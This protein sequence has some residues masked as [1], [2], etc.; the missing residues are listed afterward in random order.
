MSA[1]LAPSKRRVE[2][3]ASSLATRRGRSAL[4]VALLAGGGG[5]LYIRHVEQQAAVRR[6]KR[7]A[8]FGYTLCIT[9]I[10]HHDQLAKSRS[11]G[12]RLEVILKHACELTNVAVPCN[13]LDAKGGNGTGDD[14]GASKAV[15]KR[16]PS[17]GAALQKLLE[18]LLSIAGPK[19]L[20][21]VGLAV[22]RTALSNRLARLQVHVLCNCGKSQGCRPAS[23]SGIRHLPCSA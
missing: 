3:L 4:A 1:L 18:L 23:Q 6:Q 10:A 15:A 9:R 19:I 16:R 7:R 12:N 11:S 14:A 22:A 13:R 5:L 17:K 21:L 20:A 2:Q 8:R